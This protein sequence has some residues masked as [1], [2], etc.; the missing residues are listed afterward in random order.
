MKIRSL[1]VTVALLIAI[2]IIVLQRSQISKLTADAQAPQQPDT[3][4]DT[5][6]DTNKSAQAPAASAD[7]GVL[8][9]L[10]SE[11]A[12]LRKQTNELTRVRAEN[13]K[14]RD[15]LAAAVSKTAGASQEQQPL[16]GERAQAVARLTDS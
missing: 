9:R 10:R 5:V 15:A 14:M 12:A 16:D 7:S 1:L 2:A 11:V 6:A 4:S 8:L 13:A 3:V